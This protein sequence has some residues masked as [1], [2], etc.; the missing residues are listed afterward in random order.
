MI[1]VEIYKRDKTV[2]FPQV[3][4]DSMSLNF[5]RHSEN[6]DKKMSLEDLKALKKGNS[7]AYLNRRS[8]WLRGS[9]YYNWMFSKYRLFEFSDDEIASRDRKRETLKT[10]LEAQIII[11]DIREDKA[12]KKQEEP[13]LEVENV[14][15]YVFTILK[16]NENLILNAIRKHLKTPNLKV[17]PETQKIHFEEFNLSEYYYN[18]DDYKY[19]VGKSKTLSPGQKKSIILKSYGENKNSYIQKSPTSIND[20]I[21][22]YFEYFF[23]YI[24]IDSLDY[25]DSIRSFSHN[26][27][28]DKIES[29][30]EQTVLNVF[31]H[32]YFEG[33]GLKSGLSPH[34]KVFYHMLDRVKRDRKKEA[35]EILN[36]DLAAMCGKTVE[37]K[38]NPLFLETIIEGKEI[39]LEDETFSDIVPGLTHEKLDI[40]SKQFQF[41]FLS[42]KDSLIFSGW[43]DNKTQSL[44]ADELLMDQGN[45]SKRLQELQL[46]YTTYLFLNQKRFEFFM[47]E[48]SLYESFS[49]KENSKIIKKYFK[50]IPEKLDNK[51]LMKIVKGKKSRDT[52]PRASFEDSEN[53]IDCIK[54]LELVKVW[55]DKIIMLHPGA[56]SYTE[57]AYLS[58]RD[59]TGQVHK[60]VVAAIN[61]FGLVYF[62]NSKKTENIR[63]LVA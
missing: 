45:V 51:M 15:D 38:D 33:K 1:G 10:A 58:H 54:L 60:H 48:T 35:K 47:D 13:S 3:N 17:N 8:D 18:P 31:F 43:L 39:S 62:F 5:I 23:R 29:L 9:D 20:K 61:P 32:Y 28:R 34:Q 55:D 6:E 49:N 25:K 4:Y 50:D 37:D 7:V 30:N 12:Q 53:K 16:K 22:I 19:L 59:M 63:N 41:N 26:F 46:R 52:S 14:E 42:E 57:Y 56:K 24:W 40:L 27:R 2:C 44:I 36:V 21:E 11:R